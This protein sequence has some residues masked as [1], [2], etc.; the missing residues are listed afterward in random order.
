ME[1]QIPETASQYS[2]NEANLLVWDEPIRKTVE[3]WRVGEGVTKK[4]FSSRYIGSMVADVHRTLL[5]G[6][7]FAYPADPKNTNGKLRLVYAGLNIRS[8]RIVN[9]SYFFFGLVLGSIDA[10]LCK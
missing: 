10:D 2:M 8:T 3:S 4:T 5:Y 1:K 6:G 9:I 7:L